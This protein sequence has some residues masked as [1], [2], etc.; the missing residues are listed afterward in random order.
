MAGLGGMK[1][2]DMNGVKVYTVSGQKS[3]ASWLAPDKKRSLRKDAE[4]LRRIDLVQDLQ[5]DTAS[6]RLKATPDGQYLIA[7]GIYP[8]Q[9]RVYE[10]SELSLKFERHL[11][12]EIVNF[13]VDP[14]FI[15]LHL[16]QFCC[17]WAE[18]HIIQNTFDSV[19]IC[20]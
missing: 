11:T 4:Y 16:K 8:P 19:E 20:G 14:Y 18:C 10:L 12:S 5:F 2:T 15:S 1:V 9:V 6:T 17:C 13:Q 3:F 7:S